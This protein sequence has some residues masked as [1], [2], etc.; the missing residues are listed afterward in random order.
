[1][2]CE[3]MPE[4]FMNREAIVGED[5]G[6]ENGRCDLGEMAA[7]GNEDIGG[8]YKSPLMTIESEEL[9]KRDHLA[10]RMSG[11][12]GLRAMS[13]SKALDIVF[14]HLT[15]NK[16]QLF[17]TRR[18]PERREL[19]NAP[20]EVCD[21]WVRLKGV[22]IYE[23]LSPEKKQVAN[24][25]VY[26]WR[27]V[28]ESDL[29]KIRTT[30]LI[31]H[32]IDLKP[33]AEPARA[34][35]PLYTEAE[36]RF[37]NKLIPKMEQS[38]LILRCDSIWVARTKFPPKPNRPANQEGNL[39]MVHNYIPLNK[40]TMKSQYPC[41]RIDQIVHNVLKR[42]KR[43]FFYTDATDSYWAIPLR[44]TD[45]PLTAFTTPWGQYC[46]TVM[47]QGLKGSAHTYSR[48]RDLVFGAIP[49]DR[50][51]PNDVRAA[52]PP[53]MGDRGDIAFDGLIDDSYGAADSFLRLFTFLHEEFFPRCVFGPIYLKPSKTSL[54]FPSLEFVG[55]QGSGSGLR[56]SLRKREQIL[57]WPTPTCY[58]EVDAFCFLTPFLRRFIPGRA[59]LCAILQECGVKRKDRGRV[60][61]KWTPEKQKAFDIVKEAIAEN[62]MAPA[63]PTIQ[64]HLAM[65]A[66]QRG[67]G[68]AL[69]QLHGIDAHTE[70]TNCEEHREAER[71]I[72]FMTFRLE[73]AEKRYT[74][75]ERE[76]LAVM[77][78]LA[79]VKWLIVA[80]PYPVIVYTDHQAL[81]T[82]LT[83]PA[84]DSHGRIA[85]WQQRL[86]EYDVVLVHR[87][88]NTH[89]MGIADGMSRMPTSL[90]GPAFAEDAM[91]MDAEIFDGAISRTQ[92]TSA[93][94]I[95]VTTRVQRGLES[96]LGENEESDLRSG[97]LE[98]GA[99]VLRWARWKKFL[100]S[101]FYKKVVLFKLGG[102]CELTKPEVDVGRNEARRIVRLADK[103]VLADS[104]GSQEN[105]GR[106][107]FKERDGSLAGCVVESEVGEVLRCMH[108]AHGHFAQ[109][110]TAGR[111]F[112]RFYWP[113]RNADV[114]RW[115]ATCDS[116]Q[117][118]GP[119]R[120]SGDIRPILQLQPNDM[121]GIDYIG[122][123]TPTCEVTGSRY[124]LII[125]DYFSRFLFARPL[126]DATM[127]STMDVILNHVTPVVGWP[128]SIYS[129]NGSH[130]T[131]KDIQD[132]FVQFGVTHFPAAISHPSAVGL[133][134]RY[135]QMLTGRIRLR[136]IDRKSSAHWGLL[137]RE[138]VIDINTR[139][140]RLHGYT[141][142]EI[143]LGYNPRRTQVEVP[144]DGI[145]N[146]L[147]E[148]L[149]PHDVLGATEAEI[150]AY[151]D[152]RDE[153]AATASERL[154]RE[155]RRK[156]N[157]AKTPGGTYK[158]PEPGDLVLLRDLAR[159]KH[160]GRK[161]DPRWTEPRLVERISKNGMSAY[162]RAIHESPDR[163]KRYH[164]D[165]L[166]VYSSRTNKRLDE[167]TTTSYASAV[168]YSRD[169]FGNHMGAFTTGQWAFDFTDIG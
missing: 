133:A 146:W 123:I 2:R 67:I 88:A 24:R 92:G 20:Q 114:A 14:E 15:S 11:K 150:A 122:P 147:K 34:K 168:T 54:F 156:E 74:N 9:E 107:F 85:N 141:P 158:R 39:R 138:A 29:L 27:D 165:D 163:A 151:V 13:A 46:Y 45:Y 153:N 144:G 50:S 6:Y 126:P 56:P 143:L 30:D 154:A 140:I 109:G 149:Q 80:S 94:P 42:N 130:F 1:M 25:L 18:R 32:A 100:L 110:I 31:E 108:D 81:K 55:L 8:S 131:G 102:I 68:G 117:R 10:R 16:A 33:G 169:A 139:C 148:G 90:M 93:S 115:V 137:V 124:I 134:E 101:D 52:F 116:C 132:M 89:F 79:E 19:S 59:D 87:K 113:T 51:N 78:G 77:K 43:C 21:E 95:V 118:V 60:P 72:Q 83:G 127:Q 47:G 99:S 4:A 98:E 40:F 86:A 111:L 76:A 162:I 37:A 35:T 65:D 96:P 44:K 17:P 142:A 23:G 75:P 3:R 66:S 82:L 120:K 62:A 106:L 160:L 84:N 57:Q 145:Q 63:D 69:F 5:I 53:L 152:R 135:V 49:E 36:L 28:F 97:I 48:F 71:I 73:D 161:L 125:V 112:G 105:S 7:S 128:K 129:D 91:G 22:S 64:Y 70:A 166:R 121:W 12:Q 159:D 103:F 155:H 136:C 61:F 104:G 26:T 167:P 157:S 41:P 119:I 164:I 38:G 58:E